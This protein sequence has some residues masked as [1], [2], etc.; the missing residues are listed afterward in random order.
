LREKRF[1]EETWPKSLT[2]HS[3]V[4]LIT[5]IIVPIIA[6]AILGTFLKDRGVLVLDG[7]GYISVYAPNKVCFEFTP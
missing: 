6:I 4:F 2:N 3:I 1:I 5:P 7:R